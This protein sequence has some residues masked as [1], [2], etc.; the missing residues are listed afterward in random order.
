MTATNDSAPVITS[1]GGSDSA[2][3][4]LLQNA[5]DGDDERAESD[6]EDLLLEADAQHEAA[7]ISALEDVSA[8]GALAT[9]SKAL[10]RGNQGVS[11]LPGKHGAKAT[12]YSVVT[13]MIDDKP[14]ELAR[15]LTEIGQIGINLED[16]K[17]EHSPGAQIGLVELSVLPESEAKL[18]EDLLS[19]GWRLA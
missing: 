11:R 14:G 19:R 2:T 1:N 8:P 16:L 5:I 18:T 6:E 10:D 17:L 15:L 4:D 13:V 7:V 9:I 12:A 3:L